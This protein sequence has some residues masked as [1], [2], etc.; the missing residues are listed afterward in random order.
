MHR[1]RLFS[2]RRRS[3]PGAAPGTLIAPP[4]A[5]RPVIDVMAFDRDDCHEYHDVDPEQLPGLGVEQGVIWVNV[6]GLGDAEPLSRI[7]DTFGL[8]RLAME[9]VLNLHQRPKVEEFEDHLF[10][11][12]RMADPAQSGDT[13]Q[14][15]LFLGRNFVVSVQEKP[16]DCFDPVRARVRD[17]TSRLRGQRADYLAYALMDSVIDG[18]FPELEALGEHLEDL[19]DSV[20]SNPQPESVTLLHDVKR[21][22]LSLRRAVW[23]SRELL[24]TLSREEHD[25]FQPDTRPYLRDCYDHTVQLMDLIETYREIASG[26]IDV[27]ISSVSARLGEIMKVLTI[28][29]TIFMPLGF[30]ASLYGM[31]FDRA[32]SPWNMPELGWRLGYPFALALMGVCAGAMIGYFWRVGWLGSRSSISADRTEKPSA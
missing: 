5:A 26:L 29:A 25:L 21:Q 20:V 19:E 10:I 30:I 3:R 9:D 7:A 31:N 15:S 11:I 4:D 1:S 32:V 22:L 8:H 24:G 16:G 18:Y 28:I 27:Y 17:K 6:S 2:I 13:E 23:P 14:V 12:V